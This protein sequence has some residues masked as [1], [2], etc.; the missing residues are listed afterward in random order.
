M[1]GFVYT[2]VWLRRERLNTVERVFLLSVQKE[3]AYLYIFVFLNCLVE[4]IFSCF[5]C[6]SDIVYMIIL[7]H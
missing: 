3:E 2:C 7:K 6:Y 5:L 4:V 1:L